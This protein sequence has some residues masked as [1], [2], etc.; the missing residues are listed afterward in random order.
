MSID[1]SEF[2]AYVAKLL[3]TPLD[4]PVTM[5]EI[6]SLLVAVGRINDGKN[7]LEQGFSLLSQKREEFEWT[8]LYCSIG[9]SLANAYDLTAE[10][11]K[12][13]DVY[14]DLMRI[15]DSGPYIGDY[16]VFLHRRKKDAKRAFK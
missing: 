15:N 9:A 2:D 11:D 16:A 6:G 3:A 7:I 14:E 10:Y 8:R 13:A 5:H 12:E 1:D 4:D